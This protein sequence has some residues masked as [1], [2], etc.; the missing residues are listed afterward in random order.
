MSTSNSCNSCKSA[1]ASAMEPA[2]DSIL[3]SFWEGGLPSFAHRMPERATASVFRSPHAILVTASAS[4]HPQM[5]NRMPYRVTACLFRSPHQ[6]KEGDPPLGHR[7][8][9][10]RIR[11]WPTACRIRPRHGFMCRIWGSPSPLRV[12]EPTKEGLPDSYGAPL[13]FAALVGRLVCLRR[14]TC[15]STF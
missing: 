2:R 5:P 3:A 7:I 13:P 11:I 8:R 15:L 6:E 10:H 12:G 14:P 4:P 1:S 9:G